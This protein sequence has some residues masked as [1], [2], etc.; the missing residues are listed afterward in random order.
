MEMIN[1]SAHEARTEAVMND[2]VPQVVT[3]HVPDWSQVVT[4]D[5]LEKSISQVES[6]LVRWMVGIFLAF[7]TIIGGLITISLNIYNAL[8]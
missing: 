2:N 7:L 1:K 6:R 4:K 5:A 8:S 3:P